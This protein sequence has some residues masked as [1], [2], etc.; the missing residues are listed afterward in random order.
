ML[1]EVH[2]GSI[3]K[4]PACAKDSI[5]FIFIL[6][7]VVL[8]GGFCS[9]SSSNSDSEQSVLG[10]VSGM[11]DGNPFTPKFGVARPKTSK[12]FPSS[13]DYF[14]LLATKEIDCDT[15]VSLT[16]A[17]PGILSILQLPSFDVGAYSDA[18][19]AL[20]QISTSS[21]R[22]GGSNGSVEITSVEGTTISG[23]VDMS[24]PGRGD[25]LS[26]TFEVANCSG[27]K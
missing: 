26:G 3:M 1:F 14:I 27:A 19:I 13:Q 12:D 21:G 9:C 11:F 5:G 2:L 4:T 18:P 22:T 15:D 23:S 6:L 20:V 17:T 10:T 7:S 8:A 16:E 24:D 25:S